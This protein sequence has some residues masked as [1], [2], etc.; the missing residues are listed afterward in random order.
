MNNNSFFYS[1]CRLYL[2]IAS[3]QLTDAN[4]NRLKHELSLIDWSDINNLSNANQAYDCFLSTFNNAINVAIPMV[5]KRV[6]CYSKTNKPWVTPAIIN[7]IHRKNSLY[8]R[9]ILKN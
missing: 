3:R 1:V 9:Y 7:S 8:K 4:I 6:K 5:Q 2:D